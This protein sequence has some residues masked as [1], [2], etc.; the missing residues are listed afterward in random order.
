MIALRRA[1]ERW[2]VQTAG[3]E[4]WR[5]FGP[6]EAAARFAGGFERIVHLDDVHLAPGG[7]S[8]IAAPPH[9]VVVT[10][11]Y[12]GALAQNDSTGRSG[13]VYAG[14]FQSVFSR[15]GVRRA[16]TNA[17]RTD[18]AR[19]LRISLQPSEAG[20]EY[21]HEARRFA[22][23]ERRNVLCPV[24]SADGRGGSLRVRAD[25]ALYSSLL[26]AGHHV[27][28]ALAAG[29]CAWLHVLV[30]QAR[31]FDRLLCP[32]DGAGFAHEPAV[33]LTGV[34]PCEILLID[35]GVPPPPASCQA[36]T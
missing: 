13:V 2:H 26:D 16:E 8:P 29:R 28:H 15:G 14:E 32:G 22:V 17:S 24:M 33:S 11:V 27:V 18:R 23:S 1:S 21:A 25:A 35:L 7:R 12:Q 10:Y 5:S 34:Q 30:G 6:G 19:M 36:A 3:N 20:L 31:V 4:A 9:T